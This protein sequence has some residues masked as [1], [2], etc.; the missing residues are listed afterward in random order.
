MI[1]KEVGVSRFKAAFTPEPVSLRGFN[2]IIGRNGSG[3]S[4]LLEALQW[5]DATIRRDAREACDRYF[6]ASDL[7]NLRSRTRIPYFELD[8]KWGEADASKWRYIIRVADK[9]GLPEIMDERLC[10]LRDSGRTAESFITTVD[11]VRW[12]FPSGESSAIGKFPVREPDRLALS[13][14][15]DFEGDQEMS[16][17]FLNEFWQGAVFLRLSPNRLAHGSAAT[18][19]S[20]EPILDEEG[21]TLPALLHELNDEQRKDL[22]ESI[23]EI[24]D[25]IR[26]VEV[27]D[28]PTGRD[29]QV[30]YN[31]LER[32]PYSGRSGRSQFPI[33]AWMLSEGTRRITAI[34]AL[35]CREPRPSLICIEEVENGLDPW[36]VKAVL[37]HL[38]SAAD[39][40]VQVII[41]THSPWVLDDVPL[42]SIIHV[43]RVV[44]TTQYENFAE[45]PEVLNFH[46]SIPAGTRYVNLVEREE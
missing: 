28:A 32:M 11:G 39:E 16:P 22:V 7:I 30:Y 40:G 5:L 27:S 42:N 41:T 43:R 44:G 45:K 12:V 1:L 36:T 34:L 20:F 25:G 21:Q 35:L 26:N 6:G 23:R 14:S 31:L 8:L 10:S 24:L 37:R 33:P 29:A 13:R 17:S 15:T 46:G 9:K 18:R 19:R 38:Q 3:K 4:T 2:V